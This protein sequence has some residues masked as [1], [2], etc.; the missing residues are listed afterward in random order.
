MSESSPQFINELSQSHFDLTHLL[1]S[2]K[3]IYKAW[4]FFH[5]LQFPATGKKEKEKEMNSSTSSSS[6]SPAHSSISTTAIVGGLSLGLGSSSNNAATLTTEDLLHNP[7]DSISYQERKDEAMLGLY[8]SL[9]FISSGILVLLFL[10][11][12]CLK[13]LLFEPSGSLF[14]RL[15]NWVKCLGDS[16]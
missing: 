7:S 3:L 9:L 13:V 10:R 16:H 1:V 8:F 11:C 15:L 14:F 4:N 5:F 2:A 6:S 12:H